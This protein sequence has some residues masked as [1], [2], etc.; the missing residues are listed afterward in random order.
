[1]KK[2]LKN[3]EKSWFLNEKKSFY[4]KTSQSNS[5][6]CSKS[7]SRT[8]SPISISNQSK[9]T[10]ETEGLS[11]QNPLTNEIF[12]NLYENLKEK[13]ENLNI[14][15]EIKEY[16]ENHL[17]NMI[18]DYKKKKKELDDE[19]DEILKIKAK[20]FAKVKKMKEVENWLNE[21][22]KLVK[23]SKKETFEFKNNE[24]SSFFKE[25]L[26]LQAAFTKINQEFENLNKEKI[27]ICR[28]KT[29]LSQ[30]YETVKILWP[31]IEELLNAYKETN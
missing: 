2:S 21:R 5:A 9:K 8:I 23:I 17:Q 6:I 12:E 15:S 1:M 14:L 28:L 30:K 18:T 16:Q 22:E 26:K 4:N 7:T 3:I 20:L 27:E 11:L 19:R 10:E 13:E 29:F 25:K 31:R 24:N